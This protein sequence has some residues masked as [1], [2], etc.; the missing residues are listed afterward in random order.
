MN[1]DNFIKDLNAIKERADEVKALGD[2]VR[3]DL[4]ILQGL[5]REEQQELEQCLNDIDSIFEDW[6]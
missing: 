2:E 5:I 3:D 4:S 1:R 6:I